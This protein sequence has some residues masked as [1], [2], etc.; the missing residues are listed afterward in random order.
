MDS[1]NNFRC[2][3]TSLQVKRPEI[4]AA[5]LLPFPR[6]KRD[7]TLSVLPERNARPVGSLSCPTRFRSSCVRRVSIQVRWFPGRGMSWTSTVSLNLPLLILKHTSW[8]SHKVTPTV[9]SCRHLLPCFPARHAPDNE[10]F[11]NIQRE[12]EVNMAF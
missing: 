2:G 10:R 6:L 8:K 11:Q 3:L 9:A 1:S 7:L 12:T 4:N 5:V